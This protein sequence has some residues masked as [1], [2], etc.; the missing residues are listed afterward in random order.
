MKLRYFY[1]NIQLQKKLQY[2]DI[3][4]IGALRQEKK[5]NARNNLLSGL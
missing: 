1:K 4:R 5:N 3:C 2:Y